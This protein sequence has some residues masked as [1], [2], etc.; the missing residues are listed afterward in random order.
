[1]YA[2]SKYTVQPI[3]QKTHAEVET[4]AKLAEAAYWKKLKYIGL[5][6]LL[7]LI[8]G[9]L[10]YGVAWPKLR[11]WQQGRSVLEADRYERNGDYR[12]AL[13]TLEQTV[14]L[15]PRNADAR[16]RLANFLERLGQRQSLEHWKE[17]VRTEPGD[18]ENLIGLAAAALR[19]GEVETGRQALAQLRETGRTSKDY[20]RLS[21]GLALMARDGPA[22]ESALVELVRLQPADL[23]IQLNLAI[24]RLQSGDPLKAEAGRAALLA[25]AGSDGIRTRAVVEL[26]NDLSRRWPRPA[27]GR[28]EAFA[29]LAAALTPAAGP[30]FEPRERGD[31]VER[32]ISYAMRQPAPDPEDVGALMSW[33]ILNGRAGAAFAWLDGLPENIRRSLL[34]TAPAAEAALRTSDWPHLRRLLLAGAW[35]P[36]SAGV[37]EAAY[38]AR[39]RRHGWAGAV[40]A[41]QA[42][43]TALR[44]LLRLSDAWGWP[45]EQRQ[46]LTAISQ[47]FANE[48]WAWRRLISYALTR[49]DAEQLWQIYQRW[50]RALPGDATVQIEAAI[51]G[52][53]LE[54]RGAPTAEVTAEFAR[55]QPANPGATVAQALALWRG[56]RLEEALPLLAALPGSVWEEPRYALAYGLMLS[57]AGRAR[58][59]EPLLNRAA[60][61]RLLPDEQILIEQARA[62]NR[63]RLAPVRQP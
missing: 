54:K 26:L 16:R 63:P 22:L 62:R 41:G 46:V 50:S 37:V 10:V 30:T 51:V 27:A 23:R 40:E 52:L 48:A 12:R 61:D 7:M 43:L 8:A 56:Q 19:F 25:L 60:A 45:E 57:A 24:T 13:L 20:H 53:L 47:R 28:A 44:L 31:P 9:A 58:E 6:V 18:A 21:A 33:L 32:L 15:Y 17:L 38:A 35:G 55:Q 49:G 42:S 39:E 36:V 34:V 29:E 14:Q 3:L 59:S 11:L 2:S 4:E 1:V 5:S